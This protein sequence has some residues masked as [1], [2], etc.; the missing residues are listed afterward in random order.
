MKKNISL[1][2]FASIIKGFYQWSL[3]ILIVKFLSTEDVGYFTLAFAVTAPIFMFFNLQLKSIYVVD[4]RRINYSF[5]YFIIRIISLILALISLSIYS[6]FNNYDLLVLF[7]VGLIKALESLFDI[8]HADFQKKESMS[9]MSVSIVFQS[10]SSLIVFTLT[11]YLTNS[12]IYSLISI[13]VV[14]I[15]I[16]IIYDLR[17]FLNINGIN[18]EY[19][20]FIRNNFYK[21]NNFIFIKK[22][23]LNAL[24]LGISVFIG[25]YLTNL[26][27]I[28][29]EK[30]LGVEQLAYFGAMSY[31][32]IG[33][34]QLLLPLQTVI[35]PRL[36]NFLRELKYKEF[37]YYLILSIII[38]LIYG[39][40][41]ILIFN[42]FGSYIL[43]II[44]NENYVDYLNILLLLLLAQTIL[45]MSVF[46]NI[47]VQVFH[48]FK[49]Q[50][51]ASIFSLCSLLLIS[52]ILID[53]YYVYGATYIVLI[54]SFIMIFFYFFIFL[55]KSNLT[56]AR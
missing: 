5:N 24:P 19:L 15:I 50:V 44:Y 39:L 32:A 3:L 6:Y 14:L 37:K 31:M 1:L 56:F 53:K 41:L 35:R 20:R 18:L 23:L 28:Y 9:F 54:N 43:T 27:R 46:L 4:Y 30:Y 45:T 10:I 2:L 51:L 34:F 52:E 11:L 21:M 22:L 38:T 25:S 29:V 55:L 16:F 26:P 49:L 36:A 47:A 12:L 40:I 48:I 13:I 8:L 17:I 42:F 33:F 7:L